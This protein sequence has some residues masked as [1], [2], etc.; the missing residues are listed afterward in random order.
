MTIHLLA[1]EGIYRVT[2]YFRY[3]A[4]RLAVEELLHYL[5]LRMTLVRISEVGVGRR[6]TPP[7]ILHST[8]R[9][10]GVYDYAQ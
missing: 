6:Q 2:S 8:W 7:Y 10:K 5:Y 4:N 9:L 1:L 3:R